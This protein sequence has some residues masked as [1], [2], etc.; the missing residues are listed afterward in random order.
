MTIRVA[1][2]S[3][4]A[5]RRIIGVT[6]VML[7]IAS[8]QVAVYERTADRLAGESEQ[9]LGALRI[10]VADNREMNAGLR[11]LQIAWEASSDDA[12]RREYIALRDRV[13]ERFLMDRAAAVTDFVDTVET[14]DD[15]SREVRALRRQ[16]DR[17]AAI[18]ANR[19][20]LA[21]SFV[22]RP[23]LY[24]QPAAALIGGKHGQLLRYNAAL[25]AM[26]IGERDDAL[27]QL[28]GLRA[29]VQD[30]ASRGRIDYA[31][32]RLHYERFSKSGA[33]DGIGQALALTR[34]SLRN[35]AN[36]ELP[37]LL[38]DY[39][40]AIESNAKLVDMDNVEGF[41]EGQGEGERGA[42]SNRVGDF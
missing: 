27:E 26:L 31:L 15:S 17:I 40:L 34:E 33:V 25:H 11:A 9:Q 30:E 41:G 1:A 32:A 13:G 16:A 4:S 24:L 35:D 28:L 20:L 2:L 39:L 12:M 37:L 14:F 8:G 18:Y 10:E 38:L 19:S 42:I 6:G 36:Q 3:R 7:L 22:E 29:E 23:P 21:L 5:W